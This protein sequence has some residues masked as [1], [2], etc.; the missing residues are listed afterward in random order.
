MWGGREKRQADPGLEAFSFSHVSGLQE[1][2]L[3][4]GVTEPAP[5]LGAGTWREAPGREEERS[6]WLRP[7]PSVRPEQPSHS[8]ATMGV[9][10][11]GVPTLTFS[12]WEEYDLC[13][14]S[15]SHRLCFLWPRL[16]WNY[17][18]EGILIIQFLLSKID[19]APTCHTDDQF[20]LV[21]PRDSLTLPWTARRS[22]QSILKDINPK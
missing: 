11:A 17:S 15:K 18:M 12:V 19:M 7:H 13:L 4:H 2:A 10:P 21:F 8:W 20:N 5:G 16:S 6:A 14:T 3:L 9:V 22:N 1:K